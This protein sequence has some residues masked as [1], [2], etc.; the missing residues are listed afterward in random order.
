MSRLELKD[1][2]WLDVARS[3]S[4]L[5]TCPRRK[6]GCVLVSNS[7]HIMSTGYNGPASGH[8]HCTD[9][10][11]AGAA[12][13]SGDGLDLCEALH[14]E[15]NALI[16]CKDHLA[17]GRAYVTTFPCVTCLKMLLG[18]SCNT[19]VY[20]TDYCQPQAKEMWLKSGRKILQ[21]AGN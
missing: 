15:V 13:A 1:R 19:I 10:P 3:I 21:L 17:I 20:E 6:V 2:V 7:G 12:I 9:Y 8:P 11:C 5:A 18:T 16:Q 14:A 4:K